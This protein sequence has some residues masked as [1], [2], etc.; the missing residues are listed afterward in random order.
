MT[1]LRRGLASVFGALLL[2]VCASASAATYEP[3]RK[4]DPPPG[5]CKPNDCSLR[6]A[7]KASNASA[8]VDDRI[9]LRSGTY[10]L[11]LTGVPPDDES[12]DLVD[13]MVIRGRGA[14]ETKIDVNDLDQV[15]INRDNNE[16]DTFRLQ[17][18]T[19]TGGEAPSYGG[20]V[21][22]GDGDSLSLSQVVAFDN[23]APTAG[24]AVAALDESSL[25]VRGSVLQANIADY[26]GGIEFSGKKLVVK[27]STVAAN[28]A[29]EGGGLDLRPGAVTPLT[30]ISA[31][32]IVDN[33]AINKAAGI[34]ADGLPFSGPDPAA[35]PDVKIRNST[36]ALNRASNDAG[37]VMGDNLAKVDIANSSIGY[38]RANFGGDG[39]AVAGGVYQH[40][41]AA[42]SINDSVI[43]HNDVVDVTGDE[44]CS[45]TEVFSGL[46]NAISKQ[47]GCSLSFTEPFNSYSN[48]PIAEPPADNGGPT[49]T[50]K[51]SPGSIAIGLASV[52]P[53]RDQRGKLRPANCDSGSYEKSPKKP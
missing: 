11:T 6:E 27:R 9:L 17:D 52:C 42:F 35:N 24:G 39:T 40:S 34:L 30:R 2:S 51:L 23:R 26:G 53:K 19:L 32:T 10:E 8:A 7:V 45:A 14:G 41:N 22:V 33:V 16:D 1:H 4:D 31:S 3:T 12:L 25:T 50:L 49:A 36:I 13:S 43:A 44:D 15:M 38:N 29:D 48:D 20:A 46:G 37:G 21:I 47:T 5:K 28:L 18:L